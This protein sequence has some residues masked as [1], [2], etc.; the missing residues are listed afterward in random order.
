MSFWGR[1][2]PVLFGGDICLT[3]IVTGPANIATI[4]CSSALTSLWSLYY[5]EFASHPFQPHGLSH[6]PNAE[7]NG[8]INMRICMLVC[9]CVC[10]CVCV[11]IYIYS[12]ISKNANA[13]KL[14]KW[15]VAFTEFVHA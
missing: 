5:R 3:R 13:F 7:F 6:E 11:Y 15:N 12:I 2:V 1:V 8:Y 9:V 14:P 10:V 4:Y